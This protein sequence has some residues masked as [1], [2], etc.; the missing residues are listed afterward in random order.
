MNANSASDDLAYLRAL[1][2]AP[3]N[4][5]RSFGEAYFAAGACYGLQMLAHAA[6]ALGW[7]PAAGL[8]SLL[9]GLG[10]TGVFLALL[11]WILARERA[12]RRPAGGAIAKAVAAVLSA[13][14]LA[15][16]IL[17]LVIG[18]VAWREKSLTIWLI[19]PCTVMVLQGMAWFVIY[20]LRR[21]PWFAW[22]AVGWF[23]TAVAM[24]LGV[25]YENI[26]LFIGSAGLGFLAFM[27]VPGWMMMRNTKIG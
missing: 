24:A 21:R 2:D 18:I 9:I 5:Q 4:F 3:G 8:V 15:N 23:V 14:G 26:A 22:V 7:L 16:L 12:S 13:V 20:A 1:V 19:Y 11:V 6:Q 17:I 25:A 10:P 27:L